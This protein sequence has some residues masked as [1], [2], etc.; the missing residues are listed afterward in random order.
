MGNKMIEGVSALARRMETLENGIYLLDLRAV[1]AYIVETGK[2]RWILVD[3]GLEN[4]AQFI[5]DAAAELFGEGARP[6]AIVLTHGHFDHVGSLKALTQHY[7]APAYIHPNELPYITG[8]KSYPLPGGEDG[9]DGEDSAEKTAEAVP[10]TGV[11]VGQYALGLPADGSMPFANEWQWL[12]TPGHTRG[13]VS[14]FRKK[15]R[16]LIAGDAV[17]TVKQESFWAVVT[18]METI[19]GP[20]AYMTEDPE[21][22][23]ATI[24][25]IVKLAPAFV[26][27]GHGH[28][29]PGDRVVKEL[30]EPIPIGPDQ[31]D[32]AGFRLR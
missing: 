10:R 30:A 32:T 1:N 18:Q 5:I 6:D 3:T 11:D 2:A 4:S 24:A 20:P 29:V 27:P 15:D 16:A 31:P 21:Q 26:L 14:F 25:S 13:H 23:R 19:G 8:Q 28:P 7:K 22:S 9:E 12:Y 17:S